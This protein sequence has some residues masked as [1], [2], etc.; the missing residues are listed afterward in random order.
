MDEENNQTWKERPYKDHTQ[1]KRAFKQGDGK[2]LTVGTSDKKNIDYIAFR[3]FDF[4]A[5]LMFQNFFFENDKFVGFRFIAEEDYD[6][7]KKQRPVH[8]NLFKDLPENRPQ[9]PEGYQ[10]YFKEL[11]NHYP[12]LKNSLE[13]C[14]SIIAP[15][16]PEYKLREN[17]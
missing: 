14:V 15:A 1:Y 8:D 10:L 3:W 2:E 11:G 9:M 12:S 6:F 5:R 4:E 16:G 7:E 17:P 13:K